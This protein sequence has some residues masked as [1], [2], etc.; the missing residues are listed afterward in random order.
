V[1]KWQFLGKAGGPPF[2]G[3]VAATFPGAVTFE[4]TYAGPAPYL[5]AGDSRID[6]K[7]V[8]YQGPISV[9]LPSTQ[10]NYFGLYVAGQ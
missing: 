2:L 10:S 6:F 7:V 8:S 9:S 5:I 1:G 3:F 4:V